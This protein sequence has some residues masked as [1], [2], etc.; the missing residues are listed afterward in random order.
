MNLSGFG[1]QLSR[2]GFM[3]TLLVFQSHMTT[4]KTVTESIEKINKP[5]E[6]CQ[7]NEENNKDVQNDDS[8]PQR[9]KN[10]H[11]SFCLS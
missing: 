1:A 5:E 6:I 10:S 4:K 9:P 3:R 2:R 7:H 11:N 8:L